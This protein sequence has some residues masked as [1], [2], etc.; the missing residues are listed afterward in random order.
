MIDDTQVYKGLKALDATSINES[1]VP[2]DNVKEKIYA[3]RTEICL[4]GNLK[5][6]RGRQISSR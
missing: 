5:L 6:F 3:G 2:V 4:E 1:V